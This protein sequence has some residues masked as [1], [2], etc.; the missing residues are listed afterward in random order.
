MNFTESKIIEILQLLPNEGPGLD[1]K[2][3]PYVNGKESDMIK[4]LIA[5]LNAESVAYE[6]K[7]IIFGVDDSRNLKG[8]PE[9]LWRDD[10]Q[11]QNIISKII[12]RPIDI[13]T[14][15][16]DYLGKKFGYFYIS[17]KNDEWIYEA[18]ETIIPKVEKTTERNILIRGQAFT[19]RGS[20]NDILYSNDRQRILNKKLQS[21][22][23]SIEIDSKNSDKLLVLLALIGRWDEKYVKDVEALQLLLD[24]N[25]IEL[26]NKLR[27]LLN[28]SSDV[29]FYTNGIWNIKNREELLVSGA[30]YIFDD[31]IEKFFGLLRECFWIKDKRYDFEPEKRVSFLA[32]NNQ[33]KGSFSKKFKNSIAEALAILGNNKDVFIN[34]H[35]NKIDNEIYKFEHDFF[36][37]A[38][39]KMFATQADCF[40]FLG[41]ACPNVFLD[42]IIKLSNEKDNEFIK[43]L[44]EKE[45]SIFTVEYGYQLKSILPILAKFEEYFSRA[46]LAMFRLA[47]IQPVFLDVLVGVVL[48]WYPQTHAELSSRVGVFKGFI[49]EN[50]ELAWNALMK[51]LPGVTTTGNPIENPKYLKIKKLPEIISK[52]EYDQAKNEYINLALTLLDSDVNRIKQIIKVIGNVSIDIQKKIIDE[53]KTQINALKPKDREKIWYDIQDF[54]DYHRKFSEATWA[55]SENR[56]C[57]LDDLAEYV[58]PDSEHAYIVRLFKNDQIALFE[59][60]NDFSNEEKKLKEKQVKELKKLYEDGH[61]EPIVLLSSEVENK[62]VLGRCISEFISDEDIKYIINVSQ[63]IEG[64]TLLDG[65]VNKMDFERLKKLLYDFSDE[66]KAEI[67]AKLPLVD[68]C[69]EYILDMESEFREVYWETTK[70]WGF[71]SIS[72]SNLIEAV[73]NLNDVKRTD[74]SICLLFYAVCDNKYEFDSDVIIDTLNLNVKYAKDNTIDGYYIQN[75]IKWLQEKD[76]EKEKMIEIEWKYLEFLREEEGYSPVYIWNEMSTNPN[77]FIKVIKVIYGKNKEDIGLDDEKSKI[78]GHYYRLLHGWKTVPGLQRNGS[79]DYDILK[80]WMDI[81]IVES[82]KFDV[83]G[84]ALEHF[85][86]V[87]FYTPKDKDGFFIDKEIVKYLQNDGEGHALV[88]YQIEAINS[89]GTHMIDRTGEAEFAIEKEYINKATEAEKNGFIQFSTTLREIAKSYH[90]EGERNRSLDY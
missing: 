24:L 46:M 19:R 40:Q 6:D 58:L 68:L 44:S 10:N 42:E 15:S 20:T 51:L 85:G 36:N 52:K 9:G 56:L 65:L 87:A 3:I 90:D 33:N 75:L 16:V 47:K 41:E 60:T 86:K 8:I 74:K 35:N 27:G 81:V 83:K 25:K 7:Y 49:M 57:E 76:I 12:P 70:V 72:I 73:D 77:L 18:K 61:I 34:C 14:G 79:I 82:A 21:F 13:R 4:D 23:N 84:V 43:Y 5:M 31:H 22:S 30:S 26:N 48:P 80:N 71:S 39:W 28:N 50:D 67:I 1:Y 59:D 2:Q 45:V 11:W 54:L 64:D 29:V 66:I 32:L 78:I 62:E 69:V 37:K 38:D 88:G 53:I 63:S 89:R 17:S 55:L